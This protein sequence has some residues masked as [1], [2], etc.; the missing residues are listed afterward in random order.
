[1]RIGLRT[2]APWFAGL[3][4]ARGLHVGASMEQQDKPRVRYA[5]Q[6]VHDAVKR[7][8]LVRGPCEICGTAIGVHGHHDDYL[9]PLAVRWLCS[10]CHR[11]HHLRCGPGDNDCIQPPPPEQ[12]TPVDLAVVSPGELCHGDQYIICRMHCKLRA[13]E[14]V[15]RMTIVGGGWT[16]GFAFG[17]VEQRHEGPRPECQRCGTGLAVAAVLARGQNVGGATRC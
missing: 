11:R 4:V 16:D 7:G 14:C 13:S 15:R 1:M 17:R 10:S 5:I 8:A 12:P 3:R 2:W 9:D 6:A